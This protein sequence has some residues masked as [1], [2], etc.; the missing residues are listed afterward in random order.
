M[1]TDPTS[2][3]N[4]NDK[5]K[6]LIVDDHALFRRGLQMVLRQEPDIDVIGEA[7]D[8]NE[9]VAECQQ[10]KPDVVLMD[11]RMPEMDGI[12]ATRRLLAQDE[13][14][15]KVVMLTTFDMDEYVYDAL[16]AGASGFLLKDVPPE[17]RVEGIA[18]DTRSA[19][20]AGASRDRRRADLDRRHAQVAPALA[21]RARGRAAAR[22]RMR[23]HPGDRPR[24]PLPLE[25][26]RLHAHLLVLPYRY[27]AAGAQSHSRRDRRPDHGR[28]GSAW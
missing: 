27:A 19:F 12:E 3:R 24:H 4:S 28:A 17:Q 18:R 9:A 14:K 5:L 7:A 15:T 8:G 25:P 23:L 1:P 26:G 22:D 20:H 2:S 10:W 21:R 13:A 16:R 11:V 6:V